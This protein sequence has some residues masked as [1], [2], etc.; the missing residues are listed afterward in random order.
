MKLQD[1]MLRKEAFILPN[2]PA[3]TSVDQTE[4][5]AG[6]VDRFDTW[7]LEIPFRSANLCVCERSS[8]STWALA[9]MRIFGF[10][11]ALPSLS[12]FPASDASWQGHRGGFLQKNQ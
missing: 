6:S 12:L 4:L 8:E 2:D 9:P 7:K 5:V 3:N 10:D 1:Q 11:L